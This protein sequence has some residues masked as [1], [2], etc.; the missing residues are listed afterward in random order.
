MILQRLA[1]SIRKQ[2]WFAV[3]I[4]T[5]IVVMGV[6]LGIQLGN[7]NAAR[8]NAE[9][10][11]LAKDRLRSEIVQNIAQLDELEPSLAE[12]IA[13]VR[14]AISVLKTCDDS[15]D[16]FRIVTEGL[17]ELTGTDGVHMRRS[18]LTEMTSDQV[19]LAQQ[20]L[21][22][23]DRYREL[24]YYVDLAM[25]D[26]EDYEDAPQQTEPRDLPLV[27]VGELEAV[28]TSY[29]GIDFSG[30]RRRLELLA[31]VSEACE[32]RELMNAFYLWES[33]QAYIPVL[34]RHLR[35]QYDLTLNAMGGTP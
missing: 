35:S 24:G 22:E 10:Y 16:N 12:T 17:N 27:G 20:S 3:I 8:A 1:T 21:A 11:D 31:P 5:L 33:N 14:R 15:P 34:Y 4:E 29:Y 28:T 30:S 2:D 9:E 26:G 32:N 25:N 19:L 7:W 23:R 13:R 6:Y 18:A